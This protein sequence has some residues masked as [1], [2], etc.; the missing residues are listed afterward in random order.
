MNQ[1]VKMYNKYAEQFEIAPHIYHIF[2]SYI[3]IFLSI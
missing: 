2:D 1:E 3:T